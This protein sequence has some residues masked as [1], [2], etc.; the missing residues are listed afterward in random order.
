VPALSRSEAARPSRRTHPRIRLR[1]V[2]GFPNPT[3]FKNVLRTQ[4]RW[5]S[6][7]NRLH[8]HREGEAGKRGYARA[9]DE[10]EAGSEREVDGDV[11]AHAESKQDAGGGTEVRR[12]PARGYRDDTRCGAQAE[13]AQG[14][15]R[16]EPEAE[17]TEQEGATEG[18]TRPAG[19][20][21]DTRDDRV[22]PTARGPV[23]CDVVGHSAQAEA[24]PKQWQPHDSR[25]RH[26]QHTA[27][28]AERD[29]DQ[30]RAA[31]ARRARSR[32]RDRKRQHRD[33]V[34]HA[35]RDDRERDRLESDPD[36]G[37]LAHRSDLD[38]IV[39]TERQHRTAR[40][41]S[42]DRCE[43]AGV[44]GPLFSRKQS[45]PTARTHDEAHEVTGRCDRDEQRPRVCERP[46][47]MRQ[48]AADEDARG[49]RDRR[50]DDSGQ[51]TA[52]EEG[53]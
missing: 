48:A 33:R 26:E 16:R 10:Q 46:A 24:A 42:T 37:E 35:E 6:G 31:E 39:E 38:E 4:D 2:T 11:L 44:V 51:H 3:G 43:A 34:D 18:P 9:R 19:E 21:V 25:A 40:G 14:R 17:R 22:P 49:N 12:S 30:E 52:V 45:T 20:E 15:R 28:K 5:A 13:H 41:G 36:A 47:R 27:A 50:E 53:R 32:R 7:R 29:D 23:R 1:G 8:R